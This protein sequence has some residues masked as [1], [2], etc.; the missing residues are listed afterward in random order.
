MARSKVRS[1]AGIEIRI[2]KVRSHGRLAK[3]DVPELWVGVPVAWTV[4][5]T[6]FDGPVARSSCWPCHLSPHS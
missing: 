1:P 3:L 6:T 2:D 4:H 5:P